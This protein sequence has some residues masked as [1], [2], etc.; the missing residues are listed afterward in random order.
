M[1]SY[2]QI[3]QYIKSK[4][5]YSVKTCWIAHMKEVCGIPVR[6]AHNRYDS[7][8]RTHPC[9][10]DKQAAIRDAFQHFNML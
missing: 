6:M 4:Y 9:P 3:Q 2:S 10:S 7:D 8:R 1:A 5:G